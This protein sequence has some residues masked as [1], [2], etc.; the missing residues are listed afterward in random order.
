[1]K[2]K[3]KLTESYKF[4]TSD[5]DTIPVSQVEETFK[6][7]HLSSTKLNGNEPFTFTK[8]VPKNPFEHDG[9]VIEDDFTKRISLATRIK[10]AT[11]ALNATPTDFFYVY[12]AD[13]ESRVGDD[14]IVLT[15]E[16]RELLDSIENE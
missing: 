2:I 12:A 9:R 13:V 7:F 6:Y 5:V 4:D 16:S 10:D 14:V 11:D 1:M 15:P 3:I 8:R